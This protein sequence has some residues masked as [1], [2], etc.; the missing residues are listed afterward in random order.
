M[1]GLLSR[2]AEVHWTEALK[3][4]SANVVVRE[5]LLSAIRADFLH[6]M[7]WSRINDVLDIGAG[8]GFM[9]CDMG[10]YAKSVT[11]LEAVPERAEFIAIRARQDSLPVYPVIGSAM[12][13]PFEAESFDLITLNGVFEY[14]GL[15]G[16]GNPRRVQE[17][18]LRRVIQLL[19]PGGYLYIG[20]ETRFSLALL[21]GARDHS[22]FAFTSLMP[23]WLANLYSQWRAHPFYGS[24]EK[25]SKYRTYTY[26]P[27]QY[28]AMLYKAGFSLVDVKG[29]Y[30]GYNRQI[31]IYD[32]GNNAE[33]STLLERIDPPTSSAGKVRRLIE[34]ASL[35][36]R[37][38]EQE[39]I[40]FA[41]KTGPNLENSMPWAGVTSKGRTVAQLNLPAKI[42]GVVF[43]QNRP[44]ELLEIE[45]KGF[46][47]VGRR[48]D[49]AYE[50]LL[51]FEELRQGQAMAM[52]WPAPRGRREIS[53]RSYRCYAFVAGSALSALL[54]PVRYKEQYVCSL[55]SRAISAYIQ[56]SGWMTE[57]LKPPN[58]SSVWEQFE[59]Q[60]EV[61]TIDKNI[62][63]EIRAGVQKAKTRKW[64]MSVIQGDF[65]AGN[66]IVQ[67]SGELTLVDWE[68]FTEGFPLGTELLRF[69]R[70]VALES[71]RLPADARR[72]L[73][74]RLDELIAT[75]LRELGYN[76]DDVRDLEAL[77]IGHQI[78]A[79][80]GETNTYP[81]LLEAFNERSA[82]HVV[83][84]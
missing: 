52:I 50:R 37:Y 35:T 67:P 43:D 65:T 84:S 21:L 63:R 31:A 82:S 80:G 6:A 7:P 36:K 81:Q 19:R 48:L 59:Q 41:R 27:R 39:V 56:L 71:R 2:A 42:F 62:R 12:E 28:E 72:R 9:A 22:G 75:S 73:S 17:K 79:K 8:M 4:P 46:D 33:R 32:I 40:L 29:V 64:Q 44:T 24:G 61:Q 49:R 14:I 13:I 47:E 1:R 78:L 76:L 58:D 30:D 10:R 53:G 34:G 54:R 16:E 15:W 23:R 83:E 69:Q 45:K 38:F 5:H 11:A 18:F 66:I 77:Y 25:V 55:I 51:R 70:D 60:V 57:N 20:I 68:H 26:T 3:E 74:W